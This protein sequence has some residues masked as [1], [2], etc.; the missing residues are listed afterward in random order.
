MPNDLAEIAKK[1]RSLSAKEKA[2]LIRVLIADLDGPPD[3]DVEQ[4]WTLEVERRHRELKEGKV[5]A[6]PADRVFENLRS[7]LKQ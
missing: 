2:E 3:D 4:A 1:A 5:Q 6:V 7:R